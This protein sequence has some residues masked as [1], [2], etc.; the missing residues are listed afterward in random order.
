MPGTPP[1]DIKMR[2]W[3]LEVLQNKK[4]LGLVIAFDIIFWAFVLWLALS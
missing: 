1:R 3:A 2:T 4:K